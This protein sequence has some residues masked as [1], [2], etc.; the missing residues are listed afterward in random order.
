MRRLPAVKNPSP[1]SGPPKLIPVPQRHFAHIHIDL[2]GPLTPSNGFNHILTVID[3]TSHWMET[4]SLANT[5]AAEVTTSLFSGWICRFG[6][7]AIITS[8]RG[9]QFTSNIW[10]SLCLLLQIKHQP[11]T[12]YHAQ[13]NG[14]VERLHR[15]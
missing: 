15:R 13:A 3:R 1:F 6:V 4:I 8:D 7:P 11:T 14:M 12:A 10:N 9:A 2:V 5:T